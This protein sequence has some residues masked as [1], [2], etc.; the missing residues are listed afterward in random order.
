MSIGNSWD[1]LL[2]DDFN[3]R[4]MKELSDILKK[5]YKEH[6][7]LPD[8]NNIFRAFYLTPI[9]NVKVVILGQDPYPNKKNATGLAFSTDSSVP[10]PLSLQNIYKE[11]KADLNIVPPTNGDLTY[12]A[13]EGV[14]L[15]NSVLTVREGVSAS[16]RN[17]GWEVFT[18]DVIR[19]ISSYKEHLVFILWG[20]FAKGKKELINKENEH[21][22]IESSHPSPF[23]ASKGFFGSKPF[24][25]TNDFLIKHGET[26]I[27]WG[28]NG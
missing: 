28:N 15:L 19:K 16:H 23:S 27:N 5:E 10:I 3:S 9:E 2:S 22:I 18:D 4:H 11:M 1:T 8:K 26:P 24:S 20:E 13:R 6:S 7:V 25:R 14:L 17:L 21:L 12:L